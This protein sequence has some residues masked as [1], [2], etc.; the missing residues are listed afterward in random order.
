MRSEMPLEPT[1]ELHERSKLL[2][3]PAWEPHVR[4]KMPLEPTLELHVRSKLLLE[5]AWELHVRSKMQ[6]EPTF[7]A[8]FTEESFENTTCWFKIARNHH[9]LAQNHSKLD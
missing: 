9:T 4:S 8:T 1:L 6:L 5:P 3:E 2:L 7:E